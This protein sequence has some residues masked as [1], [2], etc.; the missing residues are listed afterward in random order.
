MSRSLLASPAG[1]TLDGP[2]S[3]NLWQINGIN[4]GMV[5]NT[6][7]FAGVQNLIGSLSKQTHSRCSLADK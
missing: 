7:S 4:T 5:N 6:L 2:P 1:T 3:V